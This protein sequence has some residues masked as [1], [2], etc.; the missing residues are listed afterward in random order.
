MAMPEAAICPATEPEVSAATTV[1]AMEER[2]TA[3]ATGVPMAAVRVAAS[4]FFAWCRTN[5]FCSTPDK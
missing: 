4:N 2:V 5:Y 1:T 3:I